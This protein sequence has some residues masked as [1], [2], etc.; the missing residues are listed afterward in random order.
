MPLA[1]IIFRP[2]VNKETT[3]YGIDVQDV[4]GWF[5]SNLIRFRKGSPEKMGGWEKLSGN[6]IVGTGRSLHTWAALDGAKYMGL[7]TQKKFYIEDGGTY[8]DVTPIRT[9]VTLGSDPVKTGSAASGIVTVTAIAH[10]AVDGDFVTFSGATTTD[11][12]TAAQLNTEHEL[13]LIDSNSYTI[14]TGGSASSG[15]TAGGGAA[16][17]ASYQLNTGLNEEVSGVGWGAGLWGG[18]SSGYT[19]T[20]LNDSG[21]INASVTSFTLTSASDFETAASTISAN[22]ALN[23]ASLPL[24]SS[25]AFPSDGTV[26]IGS[27]KIRYETNESN[28]LGTLIRGT[29][30]TTAAAHSSGAAITFVGLIQIDDELIQYTGKSSNTIDAGVVRGVRGTTA[31]SHSDGVNVLEANDFVGWGGASSIT[32]T[33]KLRLWSQD[34]WGEDLVF[35]PLNDTPYYW[36]KTLGVGSRATTFASQTGASDA[37]TITRQIMVST[38]DRHIICLGCNPLSETAQDLLQVRWCDQ[39]SPFDWTPSATNTAGGQ[40]LSS[41]SEIIAAVKARQEIL[42]WTDANLHSMRFT[43]TPYTFGFSLVGSSVSAISP[44]SVVAVGDKIFWMDTENFY[45]YT[46]RVQVIP[47]TVL[48]YLFDDVNLDQS[49]K[50]FAASNK[51]FDEILWFYAS[52]DSTEIDR[53]VKFNYTEN[54]WD[55]GTLE[56]TAWVDHSI[57]TRPRACGLSD[58]ANAVFI[59][60]SGENDDGSAMSSYI[61]SSDFDLGDGNNFMFINRIIPD[62]DITGTDSTVNY[63]LKTRDFP[64][65]S[66]A[67][68]STNSVSATTQQSFIRAR[69]RQAVIRIESNETDVAWTTGALRMDLR[70]D[71]RR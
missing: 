65:D 52:A 13:T 15:S 64:G 30:G 14:D 62:I 22:V 31:A 12:I 8:N 10:G 7:G 61:E 59:H 66:L 5:D 4:P 46:G 37:P 40:R 39:E 51:I 67:T 2:G 69:S 25:T 53:Y 1:K 24:A 63:V 28:I 44:N 45:V 41:G 68:N 29:D 32:T 58:S 17:I 50:F 36:D 38:T 43:G 42:I 70:P 11:G 54:T 56:R 47:C 26:L 18:I 57:Y 60:E 20:T 3:S 6:T 35:C 33:A 9:S 48:R 55:I 16:V 19:Q 49:R 71:G 27:E 21:G 34:N 23:A